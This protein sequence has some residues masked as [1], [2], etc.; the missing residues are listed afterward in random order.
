[1]LNR[2]TRSQFERIDAR[3]F[4]RA[5]RMQAGAS[6][7]T[8]TICESPATPLL[9]LDEPPLDLGEKKVRLCAKSTCILSGE[10][11]QRERVEDVKDNKGKIATRMKNVR[12]V[13]K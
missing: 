10:D 1:M 11:E 6:E 3:V 7:G 8:D 4:C 2:A 9:E 5:K 12:E 13:Q